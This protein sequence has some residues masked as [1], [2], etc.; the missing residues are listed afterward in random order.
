[1]AT[2]AQTA[3]SFSLLAASKQ[4]SAIHVV[5]SSALASKDGARELWAGVSSVCFNSTLLDLISVLC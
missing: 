3:V 2:Q 5:E 4:Q 1:M